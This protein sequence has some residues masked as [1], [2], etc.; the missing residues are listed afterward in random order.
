MHLTRFLANKRRKVAYRLIS[1]L[2]GGMPLEDSRW[3]DMNPI[4]FIQVCTWRT[5]L[6]RFLANK[7]RKVAYRLI[8]ILCG[9]MPLEDS[10]W[11]DMN[12]IRFIQVCT[13]RTAQDLSTRSPAMTWA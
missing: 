4:R 2:C 1:I 3:R 12:P 5:A 6:T 10:R 13:W 7:R 11:R 8:S 9:G